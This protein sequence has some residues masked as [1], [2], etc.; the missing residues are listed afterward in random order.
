MATYSNLPARLNVHFKRGDELGITT[1][2]DRSLVGHAVSA[3]L[4][5]LVTGETL[6]ALS[7]AYTST[8]DG[9]VSMS[10]TETQTQSLP[11]G[12]LG[13]RVILEEP[14]SVRRTVLEGFVEAQ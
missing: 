7:V 3:S 8:L 9:V 14:G 5:S 6:A 2:F 12:T 10:L 13:L 4:F 11:A 1:D